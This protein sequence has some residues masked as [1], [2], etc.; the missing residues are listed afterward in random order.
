MSQPTFYL[1]LNIQIAP[2]TVRIM[3]KYKNMMLYMLVN[4]Y[5]L[6][7]FLERRKVQSFF[8]ESI[9]VKKVL[10]FITKFMYYF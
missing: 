7:D 9:N 6:I 4:N 1:T 5:Q 3:I 8:Y 10:P 2:Y